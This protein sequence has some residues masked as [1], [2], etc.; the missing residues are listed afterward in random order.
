[1]NYT[2]EERLAPTRME[3]FADDLMTTECRSAGVP[4]LEEEEQHAQHTSIWKWVNCER[5]CYS[6][7]SYSPRRIRADCP[8]HNLLR[9]THDPRKVQWC[10]VWMMRRALSGSRNWSIE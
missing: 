7:W 10:R 2:V 6:A 8:H 4:P 5:C 3:S 9:R 1:M